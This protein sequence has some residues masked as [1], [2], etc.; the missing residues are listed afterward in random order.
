[1]ES[2]V[3]LDQVAELISRHA[4]AWEQ[5]GLVVGVLTWRDE[6]APWPSLLREDRGQVA[7]PDSVGV[8]VRKDQ[9]EGQ[10][11]VFRGGWADLEYWGTVLRMSRCSRL[12]AG[13]P[14]WTFPVSSDC[15]SGSLTSSSRTER[16][17]NDRVR[18][19][20]SGGTGL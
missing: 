16:S 19:R 11:A 7:E 10:L 4:F 15:S 17:M 1:M 13:T 2:R 3:D 20:H 18:A 9:Q 5:S 14:G 12:R 8:T 6:A